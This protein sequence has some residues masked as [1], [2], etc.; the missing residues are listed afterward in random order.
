MICGEPEAFT[1]TTIFEKCGGNI[2]TGWQERYILQPIKRPPT[3]ITAYTFVQF[4]IAGLK[5]K[6]FVGFNYG[7]VYVSL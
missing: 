2:I 4:C 7:L 3:D 5:L 1:S 6:G